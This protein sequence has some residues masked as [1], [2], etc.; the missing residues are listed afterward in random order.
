MGLGPERASRKDGGRSKSAGS[1]GSPSQ[2]GVKCLG[3]EAH[4][5]R[6]EVEGMREMQKVGMGAW[7]GTGKKV[8]DRQT[9]TQPWR[10]EWNSLG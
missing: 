1:Q 8:T 3:L 7:R 10:G 6:K 5:G 9:D 4:V 2:T